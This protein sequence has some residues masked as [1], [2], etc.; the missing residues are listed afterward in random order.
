MNKTKILFVC[1][2]NICRS[3]MAEYIMKSLNSDA[4]IKS[5]ATSFEE[6][7]N[8]I[9]PP[10]KEVLKRHNIKYD[11]HYATRITQED[12]DNFDYIIVMDDYNLYNLKRIIK[13]DDYKK[14]YKL[15]NF[16]GSSKDIDDPWYTRRFEECYQEIY[17]ACYAF[18]LKVRG[19][20]K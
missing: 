10:I 8:D 15:N 14:V 3:V 18:N 19:K 2:G 9:Y 12:Y 5:R 13:S 7:G 20:T 1:H 16:I 6:I 4:L 11:R 17:K